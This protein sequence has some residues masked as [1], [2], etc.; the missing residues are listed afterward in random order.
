M[1][2]AALAS[3]GFPGW[4]AGASTSLTYVFGWSA[5]SVPWITVAALVA[6]GISLTASPV[7]YQMVE[8]AQAD[9]QLAQ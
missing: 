1:A 7:V 8:K 2:V 9:I 5:D 6:I 4:A 3:W